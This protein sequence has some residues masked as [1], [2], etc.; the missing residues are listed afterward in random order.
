M[1]VVAPPEDQ[2]EQGYADEEKSEYEHQVEGVEGE[3]DGRYIVAEIVQAADDGVRITSRQPA[4]HAGHSDGIMHGARFVVG[5]AEDEQR[6]LRLRL[7]QSLE[8]GE[9]FR[10]RPRHLHGMEVAGTELQHGG[11]ESD[12]ERDVEGEAGNLNIAPSQ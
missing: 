9:F 8:S 4:Q 7:I 6:G 5:H 12:N 11:E 10:L 1:Q 3:R 2:P